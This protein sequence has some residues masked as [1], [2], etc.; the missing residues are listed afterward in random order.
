M[1]RIL[2]TGSRH[3][4]DVKAVTDAIVEQVKNATD[5][6]VIVHGHCRTGADKIADDVGFLLRSLHQPVRVERHP[7]D[8]K[9]HGRA[10]GPIR[11][12]EMVDLGADVCL[13]FPQPGS[14]GTKDCMTRAEKAGIKVINFGEGP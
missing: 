11:N 1:T 4:T 13:A 10:A 7:A 5:S 14:R 3:W 8:W 9:S 2:V 12:Q 6:A